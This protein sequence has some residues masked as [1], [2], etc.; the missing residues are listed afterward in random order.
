MHPVKGCAGQWLQHCT[1]TEVFVATCR[2]VPVFALDI[3]YL[4]FRKAFDTAFHKILIEK[5]LKRGLDEQTVRWTENWLNGQAH[6]VDDGAQCALNEFADDTTLG[7][8]AD[9]PEGCA[10]IQRDLDRLEKWAGRNLVKF[11]KGKCKVLHLG[12]NIPMHP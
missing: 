11:D 4:D 2:Y 8:M 5:L 6:R 3:V 7:G 1:T 9:T 12:R 10:A